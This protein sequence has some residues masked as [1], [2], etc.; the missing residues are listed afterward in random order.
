MNF[1]NKHT[2]MCRYHLESRWLASPISLDLSWPL[3]NC[4][5]NWEWLAAWRS[6]SADSLQCNDANMSLREKSSPKDHWTLQWKGLNRVASS[7]WRQ[8][9]GVR[10]LKWENKSDS[11]T[12]FFAWKA[13]KNPWWGTVKSSWI[14]IGMEKTELKRIIFVDIV[15]KFEYLNGRSFF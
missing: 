5:Q 2:Y 6:P 10:I 12:F 8:F 1:S 13:G 4:H 14:G 7:K 3:T 9:W 11:H 15:W